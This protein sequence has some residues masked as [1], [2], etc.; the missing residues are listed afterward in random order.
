MHVLRFLRAAPLG[1]FPWD[2]RTLLAAASGGYLE[3]VQWAYDEGCRWDSDKQAHEICEA[4]AFSGNLEL[5]KYL[6]SQGCPWSR[7]TCHAAALGG[8]LEV[9]RWASAEDC[10]WNL[11]TIIYCA[12]AG[13]APPVI[14][15]ARSQGRG[16]EWDAYAY[17]AAGQNAHLETIHWLHA[18]GCPWDEKKLQKSLKLARSREAARKAGRAR[19][20]QIFG[21]D[22]PGTAIPS[23]QSPLALVRFPLADDPGTAFAHP[24]LGPEKHRRAVD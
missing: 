20:V 21:R 6:R 7:T 19:M 15:W 16:S 13:G 22:R 23:K 12:A 24:L 14:E 8:H 4:A 3:A 10:P 18:H 17:L 5:L 1:V 2:G 11:G 9:L